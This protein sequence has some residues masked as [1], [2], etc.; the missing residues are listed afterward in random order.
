[1][2]KVVS[3]IHGFFDRVVVDGLVN[4]VAAFTQHYAEALRVIQGGMLN[5]YLYYILGSFIMVY[6]ILLIT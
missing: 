4:F 2:V 3:R 6:V 5:R 1:M